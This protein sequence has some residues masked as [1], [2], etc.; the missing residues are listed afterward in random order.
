[1]QDFFCFWDRWP[2]EKFAPKMSYNL[3]IIKSLFLF[4][5]LAFAVTAKVVKFRKFVYIDVWSIVV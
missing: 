4:A 1:M 5:F 3:K 2:W